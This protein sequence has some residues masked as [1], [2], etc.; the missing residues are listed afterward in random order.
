M[1]TIRNHDGT[2]DIVLARVDQFTTAS[3]AAHE[4]WHSVHEQ[5]KKFGG[6]ALL[7]TPDDGEWG[8]LVRWE[9]GPPQW[10][11]AYAVSDGAEAPG[12][13]CTAENGTEIRFND[14]D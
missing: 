9:S 4:L 12:F 3:D 13:T 7:R 11:D 10:A 1:P 8:F 2:Q 6:K 5:A 14:L